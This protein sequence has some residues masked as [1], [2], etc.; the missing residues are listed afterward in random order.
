MR[1]LMLVYQ[2]PSSDAEPI[3][4]G[5]VKNPYYLV[6]GLLRRGHEVRVISVP[7]LTRTRPIGTFITEAGTA[8][9]I[10]DGRGR[11]VLRYL[12]RIRQVYSALRRRDL[13]QFDVIHAHAPSLGLGAHFARM[14]LTGSRPSLV[15]TAHG[16]YLPEFRADFETFRWRDL[17]RHL[18]AGMQ[19]H[20][21]RMAFGV[22]DKV[23]AVS[24]YQVKEMVRLYR[25]P[26]SKISVIYNGVDVNRY[27]RNPDRGEALRSSLGLTGKRVVLFVGRMVPK[28]GL[29]Y[30][31]EAAPK[32]LA[33]VPNT[34]FVVVGG[35]P[36]YG[37]H[38]A[39]VRKKLARA[40]L[41]SRFVL[42]HGV[43]ERELPLY[44]AAADVCVVP[45]VNYESLPTVVLEAMAC[46]VPVVATNNWGIP[47][48]LGPAGLLVPERDWERLADAVVR[49][50][51]DREL[52]AQA[53]ACGLDRV[54]A[55]TLEASIAAYELLYRE[56]SGR[57]A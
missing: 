37:F 25:V 8:F 54:R 1:V 32:V 13:G 28:K 30:L 23:A 46:G 56:V 53:V 42:V 50:L 14:H 7:V 20:V 38:E 49:L 24:R 44:Y 11:G 9:S 15:V 36:S 27:R 51:R 3:V 26:E 57:E 2:F 41:D 22:A 12:D 29:Q 45:S 35:T 55:F 17:L 6:R 43:P 48:A 47:E 19:F 4:S 21:D 18:N 39:E 31:V 33:E 40:G 52:S 5:E 16:T 34:V 10:R